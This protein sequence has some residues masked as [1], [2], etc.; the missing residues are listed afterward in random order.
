MDHPAGGQ[1][2]VG[3][4]GCVNA[5]GWPTKPWT[6]RPTGSMARRL[7]TKKKRAV[8]NVTPAPPEENQEAG[9]GY[10]RA[11]NFLVNKLPAPET[12]LHTPR[13]QTDPPHRVHIDSRAT[14]TNGGQ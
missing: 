14:T 1:V 12:R 5:D 7:L 11:G 6:T 10:Q 4:A 3:G 13:L 9:R 8:A 2:A